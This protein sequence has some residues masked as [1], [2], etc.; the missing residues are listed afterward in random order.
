MNKFPVSE[1][2]PDPGAN[3]T[4]RDRTRLTQAPGRN[5]ALPLDGSTLP[6]NRGGVR[7]CR[8]KEI[9]TFY[10]AILRSSYIIS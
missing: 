1:Y 5:P 3:R 6:L 9:N 4:D 2:L 10:L 7:E 8:N